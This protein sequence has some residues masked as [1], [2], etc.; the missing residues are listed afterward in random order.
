MQFERNPQVGV[1]LSKKDFGQG[2][3]YLSALVECENI[4]T[5]TKYIC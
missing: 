5:T 3:Q 1:I 2:R 4:Q